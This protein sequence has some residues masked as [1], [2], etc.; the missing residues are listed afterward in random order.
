[1]NRFNYNTSNT[2]LKKKK[3][4]KEVRERWN[5]AL[6]QSYIVLR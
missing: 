4:S 3:T 6:Q 1:M 2:I 5:Y